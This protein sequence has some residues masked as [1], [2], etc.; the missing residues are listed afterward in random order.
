MIWLYA[1]VLS[2]GFVIP[3]YCSMVGFFFFEFAWTLL[4]SRVKGDNHHTRS[5][6]ALDCVVSIFSTFFFISPISCN[7]IALFDSLKLLWFFR[8][9]CRQ[10][11]HGK[12]L[13]IFSFRRL[14]NSSE[15]SDW[16][17]LFRSSRG[18]CP[19]V[20]EHPPMLW[21]APVRLSTL[22]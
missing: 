17:H 13:Y 18:P 4:I 11:Y 22:H 21:S 20:D 19:L 15:E 7:K 3:S 5:G 8:W 14:E 16:W 10:T 12:K 9:S 2:Y 6:T 1:L